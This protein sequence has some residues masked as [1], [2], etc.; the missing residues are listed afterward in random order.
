MKILYT[1]FHGNY[2]GGHVTYVVNLLQGLS[3]QHQLTVAT[4]S[5]SQLY[6][7]ASAIDGV[8]LVDVPYTTRPSSWFGPRARLKALIEREQFD[9]IHVNGS[10]DHKQV[11]LAV[12]GMRARPRIV[13][14]KHNDCVPT[15]SQT[16]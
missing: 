10:A 13:F 11:M 12:V 3:G 4:P 15:T 7:R 2:G 8:Q 1:N 16:V 5:S 9:V 14:T 6:R